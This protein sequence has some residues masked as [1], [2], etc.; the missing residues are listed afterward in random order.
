MQDTRAQIEALREQ[1]T[2]AVTAVPPPTPG[3]TTHRPA[4]NTPGPATLYTTA[5]E[6]L[7]AGSFRT[8]RSGFELLLATVSRT[9]ENASA[10]LLHIGDAH[11]GERNLTAADSVYQLVDRP[12]SEEPRC[13]DG[14]LPPCRMLS[15]ANKKDEAR[16]LANRVIKEY[17]RSDEAELARQLVKP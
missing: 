9:Y 11:K 15:D 4:A 17:P 16:V 5:N 12:V 13:A 2:A 14:T 7:K 1:G 6:Q 3:D 10:A 8:A